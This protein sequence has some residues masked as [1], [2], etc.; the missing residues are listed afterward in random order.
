MGKDCAVIC[1]KFF[2]VY[3]ILISIAILFVMTLIMNQ[4]MYTSPDE[5]VIDEGNQAQPPAQPVE[6]TKKS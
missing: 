1:L 3:S 4:F 6:R 5:I 2:K